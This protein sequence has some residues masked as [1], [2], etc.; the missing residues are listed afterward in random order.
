MPSDERRNFL[1]L[2]GD[3]IF[4]GAGAAFASQTTVVPAFVAQLTGS[5]P[6]VGL[7]STIAMGGW[8]LPQLFAANVF[9]ARRRKKPVVLV[10]AILGR[11]LAFLLAPVAFYLSGARPAA[12]AI[13]FFILYFAFYFTDGIASVSWLDLMA[14]CLH[15]TLRTRLIGVGQAGGSIA[16]IGS[17]ILVGIILASGMSFSW[18]F[19]LLF[20]LSAILMSLS[21]VSFCFLTEEPQETGQRPL[22]WSIYLG[23]LGGILKE[24]RDFRRTMVVQLL[25]GVG[26]AASPFYVIHGLEKLG[27]PEVSVGVFTSAQVAGSVVSA[28]LFGYIATRRGTRSVIRLCGALALAMPLIAFGVRLVAGSLSLTLAM[29]IY[30]AVFVLVGAQGNG[31]TAGFINYVL[32][33]APTSNR[34]TYIGLANT[35]NSLALI[36]PL[37]AGLLLAAGGSY[38]LLFLLTAAAPLAGMVL[39]LRLVEPRHRANQ[40]PP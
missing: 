1:A 32:E 17:G 29:Y 20:L 4:F 11:G 39:S 12:A 25:V 2:A 26:G 10:P 38:P 19:A 7:A 15:S 8:L 36:A 24:D 35:L 21:V 14:K 9:A 27:F 40:T 16:G 28:L 13:A 31:V 37:L 6:L 34:A 3:F 30:S 22:P 5:A 23:R 18:S 33:F